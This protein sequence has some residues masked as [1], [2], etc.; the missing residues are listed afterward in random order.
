MSS[1]TNVITTRFT[2]QGG[3][4]VATMNQYGTAVGRFG[5]MINDTTRMSER[6]NNQW[7]AFGT[8]MRYAIAGTT[9]F[10]IVR[11]RQELTQINTQLGL[12]AAI[13]SPAGG[14]TLTGGRLNSLFNQTLSGSVAAITPLNDYNNA[15]INLLSTV[16]NIPDDQITPIVTQISQAA[17]LAQIN[18]EDATKAFTTMNVAF[19]RP[20]N[21]SNIRRIAQEFFILTQQAPGGVAA[22]QQVITQIG[23]LAQ[24]TR[25][26]RGT[27]EDMMALLLSTLRSGIPPQQAGR[28]LQYLLQTIGLPGQQQSAARKA[29]GDVGITTTSDM[30]LQQRLAAIFTRARSLG[31]TG[32]TQ[33]IVKADDETMAAL[34]SLPTDQALA[35]MGITGAGAAYLG[36]VFRRIHALRTAVALFQQFNT[37]Q[38]QADIKTMAEAA[39]GHVSDINSL[40]EAWKRFQ[41]EAKLQQA[42]VALNTLGLQIA[43]GFGPIF[44][45]VARGEIG[46]QRA[47]ARHPTETRY[48]TYG[49]AG[50]LTLLGIN[51][52]TGGRLIGGSAARLFGRISG[53]AGQAFVAERAITAATAGN[54]QPGL[55]PQNPIY[56]VVV[57]QLFGGA[58]TGGSGRTGNPATDPTSLPFEAYFGYKGLRALKGLAGRGLG[59]AGAGIR[60][61]GSWMTDEALMKNMARFTKVGG[62]AA[63]MYDYFANPDVA[64]GSEAVL[65]KNLQK[66]LGP[67]FYGISSHPNAAFGTFKGHGEVWLNVNMRDATTGKVNTVRIHVPVDSW[68]NGR[69]P[70][71]KGRGGNNR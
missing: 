66:K 23:Q 63:V 36:T 59:K 2:A 34:E 50:L 57:G 20:T 62:I 11:L 6:L 41:K 69:T 32:N 71:N 58:V 1:V 56:V 30:N 54:T 61:G 28:G 21:M 13:G 51:R 19:G 18:A 67:D 15:V 42:S 44:D 60:Y 46:V 43:R 25:L 47:A 48:A 49:A 52:I 8:T 5:G 3:N 14:G 7:R 39:G 24:T 40:S 16:Q 37:G 64:G 9:I 31:M 12:M 53:G 35:Q 10:G 65:L 38:A 22:G 68:N 4:V 17:K 70:S 45:L 26:A 29:L 33:N 55:S 27:P